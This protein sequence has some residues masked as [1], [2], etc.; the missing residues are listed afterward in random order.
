MLAAAG[1][2]EGLELAVTMVTDLTRPP[3]DHYYE[4]LLSR[5]GQMRQFV[6]T[7]LR[8]VAFEG[9]AA[10]RPVLDALAFLRQVEGQRK[11]DLSDTPRGVVTR[12]RRSLV[13]DADNRVVRHDYTL[14]VLDR[15]RDGLRRHDL[16]VTPSERWADSR[17]KRF[18]APS[19]AQRKGL[20]LMPA[21]P[22]K[23]GGYL[24]HTRFPA[25]AGRRL[26]NL[27]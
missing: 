19:R 25:E 2:E 12:A 15:L 9:T 5:Y 11:P 17:A 18:G 14:C 1:G 16:F 3:E 7:L 6:P 23:R 13:R 20:D 26:T 10:G 24:A 27:A 22:R 4:H 8:T 21:S